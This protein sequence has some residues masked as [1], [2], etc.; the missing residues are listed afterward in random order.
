MSQ[1]RRSWGSVEGGGQYFA[2]TLLYSIEVGVEGAYCVPNFLRPSAGTM[3]DETQ[4]KP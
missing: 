2:D 1:G 3:S 4:V